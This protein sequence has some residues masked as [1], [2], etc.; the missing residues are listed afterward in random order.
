[1]ETINWIEAVLTGNYDNELDSGLVHG[2]SVD[3][4]LTIVNSRVRSPITK[5]VLYN[6][7]RGLNLTTLSYG[8][9]DIASIF[10]VLGWINRPGHLGINMK[11][12][13]TEKVGTQI[14]LQVEADPTAALAR[15][16]A[17][18]IVDV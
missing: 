6:H 18:L 9:Y 3:E 16:K 8:R 13:Y 15:L 14:R 11:K 7:L 17:A 12:E 5:Q 1:M 4:F 10:I 2:F